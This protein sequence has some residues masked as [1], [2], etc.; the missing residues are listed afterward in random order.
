MAVLGTKLVANSAAAPMAAFSMANGAQDPTPASWPMT[1]ATPTGYS[2]GWASFAREIGVL[3]NS[4]VFKGGLWCFSDFRDRQ[5]GWQ[6][7]KS[8]FFNRVDGSGNIVYPQVSLAMAMWTGPAWD[9]QDFFATID[10]SKSLIRASVSDVASA[11]DA[12]VAANAGVISPDAN[13]SPTA[14]WTR[15]GVCFNAIALSPAGIAAVYAKT[16]L[17]VGS[18][19]PTPESVAWYVGVLNRST[20]ATVWEAALPDVG[21]GLK[22]QWQRFVLWQWGCERR[23]AR[24]CDPSCHSASGH[25]AAARVLV[26]E[27]HRHG[28]RTRAPGEPES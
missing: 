28:G 4:H 18:V 24:P 13:A 21:T 7:A 6:K 14:Q 25:R 20:G 11:V 5:G 22:A 19:S 3:D 2:F 17:D 15:A 8:F 26:D 9:G 27:R 1:G 12:T 16:N 10:N 23:C